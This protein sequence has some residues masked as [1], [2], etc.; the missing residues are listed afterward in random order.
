MRIFEQLS[1][2]FRKV[3]RYMIRDDFLMLTSGREKKATRRCQESLVL[4]FIVSERTPSALNVLCFV[5]DYKKAVKL[6]KG[7]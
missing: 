4:F 1:S 3:M 6:Q 7:S 5:K 2:V